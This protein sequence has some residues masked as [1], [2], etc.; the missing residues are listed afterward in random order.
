MAKKRSEEEI[1]PGVFRVASDLIE[2]SHD[3]MNEYG[4]HPLF[5]SDR[6]FVEPFKN[7]LIK[8]MKA[9]RFL[10]DFVV[11]ATCEFN[12]VIY[13][14]NAKHTLEAF[15]AMDAGYIPEG[16]A[17]WHKYRAETEE[18]LRE[19]FTI[20][21]GGNSRTFA[22]QVIAKL[23]GKEEFR[24][25]TKSDIKKLVPGYRSFRYSKH[26]QKT[27]REVAE[28]MFANHAEACQAIKE[29]NK[30]YT[31]DSSYRW[32]SATLSAMFATYHFHREDF[33]A[34]WRPTLY[35]EG[36]DGD[37]DPRNRLRTAL[38]NRKLGPTADKLD[39]KRMKTYCLYAFIKWKRGLKINTMREF[40]R[41]SSMSDLVHQFIDP[42]NHY[43]KE[44]KRGHNKQKKKEQEAKKTQQAA[45]DEAILETPE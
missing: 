16:L 36:L 15:R 6:G 44:T 28:D 1:L 27:S 12:G 5:V 13:R 24:G 31:A 43:N 2:L 9:N 26:S 40:S 10:A 23:Y 18:G 14:L 33:E 19:L 8:E 7:K 25:I 38:M 37:T 45:Q 20:I 39:Q 30:A 4:E 34:F 42:I 32:I 41:A 17:V 22:D 29:L 21:D 11:L 3:I 35:G